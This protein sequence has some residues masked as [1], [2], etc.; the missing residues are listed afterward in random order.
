MKKRGY[1]D[2]IMK[3]IRGERVLD[4]GCLGSY[5]ES[6]LKRHRYYR[7]AASEIVGI[8]YNRYYLKKVSKG[9][10]IHYCDI[11]NSDN[12]H[13]IKKRFGVFKHIIATD[14]IEHIGDVGLFLQNLHILLDDNGVLYLTTPNV[15]APFY[16]NMFSGKIK[17]KINNDHMCWYELATLSFLFKR[18]S[19]KIKKV[20]FCSDKTDLRA[21]QRLNLVYKDWMGKK[22]YVI[23]E[24]TKKI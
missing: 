17:E 1:I 7:K 22:L 3:R 19:F 13:D 12:V 2:D 16:F 14:L 18:Y 11:T 5:K 21:A 15:R 10:N 6:Q 4:I 23:V 8:D 20:T 24:K 9:F